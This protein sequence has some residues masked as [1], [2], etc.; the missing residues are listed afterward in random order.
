[1]EVE[2]KVFQFND[3]LGP[4]KIIYIHDVETK[5][6]AVL[7][8]DNT[9]RGPALGGIRIASDIT[10]KEVFRLARSMTFKWA[11]IDVPLGGG[12][13]GIFAD[14]K[15]LNK[16]ELIRAFARAIKPF[17]EN[18]YIPGPDIGTDEQCMAIIYE[19]WGRKSRA[20]CGL[21]KELGGIPL[22]EL[23]ATGYGVAVAA[24]AAAKFKDL[25]LSD[26]TASIQ[27]FGAVGA[28]AA[29]F[30]AEKGVKIVAASTTQGAV[31]NP[32]GL[33]LKKLLELRKR[34]GGLCVTKYEDATHIEKD[35]LLYLDT[36]ILVPCARPDV[37]TE[38]NVDK[39]KAKLIV[40][41]ANIPSTE[42]AERILHNR[43]VIVVPDFIANAG[44]A[45]CCSVEV[46]E[47]GTWEEATKR[48]AKKLAEN[49]RI[50][51]EKA[52]REKK[53]P[54]DVA[55]EIA[56]QRVLKAMKT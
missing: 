35:D 46:L 39:V 45:L 56:T 12:K 41:G 2:Q 28:A 24:E 44:G 6:R 10:T 30:L 1:M 22:D 9:A 52:F 55:K 43:G 15:A 5:L 19:E 14:S 31:Y 32:K 4:E 13:S 49:I 33:D 23:G 7:V 42:E 21:P 25:E 18:T 47:G 27:G 38:E 34:Y 11:G 51:L 17:S 54:R 26:A 50:I 20:I 3:M 36:E 40:P 29:K 16:I 53:Y 8:I 48:I 37:I